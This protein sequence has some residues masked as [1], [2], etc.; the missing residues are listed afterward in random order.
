MAVDRLGQKGPVPLAAL[1]S[2]VAERLARFDRTLAER[3]L[4]SFRDAFAPARTLA[5]LRGSTSVRTIAWCGREA[6]GHE[7]ESAIDGALL[8]TPEEI[9][10]FLTGEPGPC[11]ACGSTEGSRW[12]FAGQP[13]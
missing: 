9:P 7:V 3:A 11:V 5:D 4:A 12:A 1:E 6:C 10:P 8:G 2:E 13:L